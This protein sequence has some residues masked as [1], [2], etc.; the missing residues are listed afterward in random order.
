MTEFVGLDL[1]MAIDTDYHEA[2]HVIDTLL[3]A[4]FKGVQD[5]NRHELDVVKQRFPHADLV[6]PDETVILHYKDG[7]KLLREA[8]H[9]HEDGTELADDED[10]DTPT[11]KRL[12]RL[13]KEKYN[14]DYYILDKFPT[15]VRPFYTM[16]DPE[17]ARYSNS[18]D[19]FVRGQVSKPFLP[20]A[21]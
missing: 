16:P 14:T 6:I 21:K 3:K 20:S 13:V 11:E 19:I 2:M 17:D 9:K 12:G 1:E 18:F 10:F 4:I 8:G 5:R 15:A 7:V